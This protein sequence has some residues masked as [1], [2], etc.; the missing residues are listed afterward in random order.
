VASNAGLVG[1]LHQV[2]LPA[3]LVENGADFAAV[4]MRA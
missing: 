3:Y 4:V 2:G 1:A